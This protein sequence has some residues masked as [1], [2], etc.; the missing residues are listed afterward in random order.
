MSALWSPFKKRRTSEEPNPSVG[1]DA[2]GVACG[3][4]SSQL[5]SQD[6]GGPAPDAGSTAAAN[7]EGIV[8]NAGAGGFGRFLWRSQ[9]ATKEDIQNLADQLEAERKLSLTQSEALKAT[10]VE[11]QG[12]FE[13]SL[14][15][16]ISEL[17]SEIEALKAVQDTREEQVPRIEAQAEKVV[18]TTQALE[19]RLSREE[20]TT[21]SLKAEVVAVKRTR[22]AD[23]KARELFEAEQAALGRT[24][25]AD[26]K[27][28]ELLEARVLELMA[29][30]ESSGKAFEEACISMKKSLEARCSELTSGIQA[31]QAKLS[32]SG[33][34]IAGLK[35]SVQKTGESQERM[36]D[37]QEKQIKGLLSSTEARLAHL[38]AEQKALKAREAELQTSMRG[39]QVKVSELETQS[40]A[41]QA[42]TTKAKETSEAAREA[43]TTHLEEVKRRDKASQAKLVELTAEL[44][45]FKAAL[46]EIRTSFDVER[47]NAEA[48]LAQVKDD[49][50]SSLQAKVQEVL[51]T[52]EAANGQLKV[53]VQKLDS[54]AQRERKAL[55]ELRKQLGPVLDLPELPQLL[56]KLM[57]SQPLANGLIHFKSGSLITCPGSL[58]KTT[59][60]VAWGSTALSIQG[61][62]YLATDPPKGLRFRPAQS[63][64][65][66]IV[67]L[68]L[69]NA[70]PG[71]YRDIDFAV[72]CW[73]DGTL[74][75]VE[76][77]A[78]Q[79]QKNKYSVNALIELRL[80]DGKVEVWLDSEQLSYSKT[81]P[82]PATLYAMA[83]FGQVGAKVTDIQW[84]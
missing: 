16:T 84:L 48:Q 34:E 81:V 4:P 43:L 1:S 11:L 42:K 67:G 24:R 76:K 77:G 25:E 26:S 51:Q 15:K 3:L 47:S 80:V 8:Q 36:K 37:D 50:D 21:K 30:Q 9:Y 40:S 74:Y 33:T 63:D 18:K 23:C 75:V 56:S 57:Q 59:G 12:K 22:D 38:E 52:F 2:R 53:R 39:L 13:A 69:T 68:G 62:Q 31:L 41:L 14:A 65:D 71:D 61:L 73:S 70:A 79:P 83:D 55:E 17:S 45:S 64:K 82:T 5:P 20:A 6:S 49:C 27:A 10:V 29:M 60:V 28:R 72:S 44:E 35:A 78:W 66:L 7:P 54:T 46:A 58:E 19:E 32:T